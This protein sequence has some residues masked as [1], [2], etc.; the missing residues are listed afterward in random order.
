MA[1][2]ETYLKQELSKLIDGNCVDFLGYPSSV[3]DAI[4]NWTNMYDAY[5]SKAQ[6]QSGDVLLHANKEGF[7]SALGTLASSVS[8]DA[9]ARAF[10]NAFLAYWSGATFAVGIS[11]SGGI[12]GTGVFSVESTS[13]A[14][15]KSDVLY[16]EL[17]AVFSAVYEDAQTAINTLANA[18]HKSTLTG[19]SIVITGLDTSPTPVTITNTGSPS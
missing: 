9:A 5:A 14:V 11:P 7:Q 15:A 16:N 12:G 19:V 10:D 13:I 1:L 17:F 6:D 4:V 3:L 2:D 18:F 8:A